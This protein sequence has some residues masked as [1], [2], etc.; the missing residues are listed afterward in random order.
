VGYVG[1]VKEMRSAYKFLVRKAEGKIPHG[2]RRCRK[3]DIKLD[4]MVWNDS[5]WT[6]FNFL[7]LWFVG[8][9]L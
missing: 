1:C 4:H 9:L 6:E 2:R 7:R 8:G 5:M 3:K